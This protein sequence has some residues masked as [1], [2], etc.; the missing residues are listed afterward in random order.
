MTDVQEAKPILIKV[1]RFRENSDDC[2]IRI[3]RASLVN[4]STLLICLQP[5]W[6]SFLFRLISKVDEFFESNETGKL[7]KASNF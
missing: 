4:I 1:I 6:K 5:N 2:W 3:S 7:F